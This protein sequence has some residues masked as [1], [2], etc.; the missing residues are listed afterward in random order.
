MRLT[1]QVLESNMYLEDIE[2]FGDIFKIK[3]MSTFGGLW[4]GLYFEEAAGFK[5]IEKVYVN[6]YNGSG[7]IIHTKIIL[8]YPM[9]MDTFKIG[10]V[11][12][13]RTIQEDSQARVE[14]VF[15]SDRRGPFDWAIFRNPTFYTGLAKRNLR[16]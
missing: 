2:V 4:T 8:M 3:V 12:Q 10:R 5:N 9:K 13:R 11:V 15:F 14:M 7:K 1:A 6:V 16:S